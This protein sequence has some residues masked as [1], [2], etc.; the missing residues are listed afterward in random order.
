MNRTS[1]PS[2]SL[3]SGKSLIKAARGALFSLSIIALAACASPPPP[4]NQS[5]DP[6]TSSTSSTTTTT[7]R[8]DIVLDRG[9][10]ICGVSG[11]VPGFSFIGSDGEY[12]GIDVDMCRAIAAALFDDPTKV[13][14]KNLNAKERFAAL[15]TGEIDILS[16]NT[17]WTASRD[18]SVG[19]EFA[20]VTFYDGQ[21][22]MV[23]KDSGITTLQDMAGKDICIQIGTTS[24]L[25]L[26]D[27]MRKRGID[28]TP[29]S[30]E[31]ANEAFNAYDNGRCVG[32][33]ADRSALNGR[34]VNLSE[35]DAHVLLE[36][37]ISKEPLAPAVSNGDSKWSDAVRWIVFSTIEAE[38]LGVSSANMG[39]MSSSDNAE[40][41]R[42]LGAEGDLGANMGLS[43][44]F[45]ARVVKH[46]GNYGEIY[47]R[48]LGPA[49]D[50]ALPRGQNKLWT[51][52][53]LMY[54]PPFR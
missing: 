38:D 3:Q 27:Q 42:F 15:Q 52:G 9:E 14:Y 20:P 31:G 45:A 35:P 37:V 18:T 47:D 11:E 41:K 5:G 28:F 54:S 53:G 19:L 22:M 17:T 32:I 12:S 49:S 48:N 6:N 25:N 33:T 46:V 50:F 10:L 24:E 43:N 44:D 29:I 26:S 8:L 1:F 13:Q 21:G 23:R 39:E 16:R 4:A 2:S 51:D 36:E 7:S 30:F 34:R 40:V